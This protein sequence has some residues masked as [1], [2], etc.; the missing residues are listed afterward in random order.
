MPKQRELAAWEQDAEFCTIAA[1]AFWDDYAC[2]TG[3]TGTHGKTRKAA[4]DRL[5]LRYAGFTLADFLAERVEKLESA[6]NAM[7][8]HLRKVA[9]QVAR[10]ATDKDDGA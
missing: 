10:I 3:Q 7:G 9:Q 6:C 8:D 2:A 5:E 4:S 1:V